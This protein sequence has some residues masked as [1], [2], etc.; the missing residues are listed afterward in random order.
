MMRVLLIPAPAAFVRKPMA[1]VG[2]GSTLITSQ[3]RKASGSEM[4]PAPPPTS[5]TTSPASIYEAMT[6]RF[7]SSGR[8]GLAFREGMVG[9]ASSAFISQR[10][11]AAHPRT[12]REHG[13]APSSIL[14]G[15]VVAMGR[16]HGI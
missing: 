3:H 15:R 12:L 14:V 6:A 7:G 10:L 8:S 11:R 5:I 1:I 2:E 4:R 16:H 9:G 13:I